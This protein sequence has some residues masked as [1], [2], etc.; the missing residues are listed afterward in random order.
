MCASTV[1]YSVV[2][3]RQDIDVESTVNFDVIST[4]LQGYR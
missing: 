1:C 2:P 4:R 3:L